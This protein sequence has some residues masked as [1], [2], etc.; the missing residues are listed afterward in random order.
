MTTGHAYRALVTLI[1][2][3]GTATLLPHPVIRRR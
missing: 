2:A 3:R 1:E